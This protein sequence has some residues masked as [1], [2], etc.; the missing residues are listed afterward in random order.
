M[1]AIAKSKLMVELLQETYYNLINDFSVS[2]RRWTYDYEGIEHQSA[3]L[4][5]FKNQ[6]QTWYED[7]ITTI[8]NISEALYGFARIKVEQG[9]PVI[10]VSFHSETPISKSH[11]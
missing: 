10:K 7:E 2:I 4:T 3:Y 6:G 1:K 11:D 5:F 8:F 9:V